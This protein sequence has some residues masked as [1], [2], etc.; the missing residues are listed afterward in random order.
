MAQERESMQQ[1]G[2][3]TDQEHLDDG[4]LEAATPYRPSAKAIIAVVAGLGAVGHGWPCP[5]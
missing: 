5:R 1:D 2:A 3:A 4:Q